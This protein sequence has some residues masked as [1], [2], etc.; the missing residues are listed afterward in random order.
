MDTC[1]LHT[2]IY[3]YKDTHTHAIYTIFSYLNVHVIVCVYIYIYLSCFF[4]EMT[5]GAS[6][7]PMW[8]DPVVQADLKLWPF[9]AG[10]SIAHHAAA[11]EDWQ[12]WEVSRNFNK[13]QWKMKIL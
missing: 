11:W 5:L 2:H 9:K 12:D 1:I 7:L 13:F 4:L 3:I 8:Q 10:C 6:A